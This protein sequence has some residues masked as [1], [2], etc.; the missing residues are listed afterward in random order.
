[1]ESDIYKI[2][3]KTLLSDFKGMLRRSSKNTA[4]LKNV[5]SMYYD[6]CHAY[7]KLLEDI[8]KLIESSPA[9]TLDYR[10]KALEPQNAEEL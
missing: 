5:G 3:R 10:A 9:N 1:M 7:D 6:G 4:T 2:S 8:V